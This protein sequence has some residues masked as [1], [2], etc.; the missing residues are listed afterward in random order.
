MN[1]CRTIHCAKNVVIIFFILVL[2][3]GQKE[4]LN[5]NKLYFDNV[6]HSMSLRD[7]IMIPNSIYKLKLDNPGQNQQPVQVS[8]LELFDFK[9]LVN[10]S[11]EFKMR[12]F[13]F[14]S[15]KNN[16]RCKQKT[17]VTSKSPKLSIS[18]LIFGRCWITRIRKVW[19]SGWGSWLIMEKPTNSSFLSI[20]MDPGKLLWT[21]HLKIV[22]PNP[23]RS[24][25]RLLRKKIFCLARMDLKVFLAIESNKRYFQWI[26]WGTS[27]LYV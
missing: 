7:N 6:L 2:L 12:H 15:E 9:D 21:L 1:H 10:I 14:F 20:S 22:T 25:S 19:C 24:I 16:F 5:L 23:I 13:L 17:R 18:W 8:S 4:C 26:A 11:D 3:F 27:A